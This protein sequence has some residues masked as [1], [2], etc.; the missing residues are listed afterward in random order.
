MVW[1]NVDF[2][3]SIVVTLRTTLQVMIWTHK[4]IDAIEKYK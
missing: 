2:R 4:H 1:V 3:G